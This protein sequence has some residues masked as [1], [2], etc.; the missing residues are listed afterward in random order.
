MA[1]LDQLLNQANRAFAPIGGGNFVEWSDRLRDVEEMLDHPE[2][3]VEVAR[4]RDRAKAIRAE[5]K[6]H[7]KPPNWDLV[8]MQVLAPLNELRDRVAEELLKRMSKDAV[9]PIDRDPVPPEF[10]E[11]VRKYY[12][13][14]GSGN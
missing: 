12:E 13:R 3:S 6:R 7:S 8:R 11:Q 14:L 9:V 2:L 10:A 1:G 4:V 5:S